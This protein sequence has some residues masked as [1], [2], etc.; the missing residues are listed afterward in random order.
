MSALDWKEKVCTRVVGKLKVQC[1]A[2]ISFAAKFDSDSS[3]L[4]FC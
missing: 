3:I 4:A 1:I 2:S